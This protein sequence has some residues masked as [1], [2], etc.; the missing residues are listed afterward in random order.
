MNKN[1][2]LSLSLTIDH[3]EGF[4]PWKKNPGFGFVD[5]ISVTASFTDMFGG[6]GVNLSVAL[7]LLLCTIYA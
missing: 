7:Y 3:I 6:M 5:I 1:L 2:F 4:F